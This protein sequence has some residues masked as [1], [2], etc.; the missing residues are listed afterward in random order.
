MHEWSIPLVVATS[1]FLAVLV[2]RVRPLVAPGTLRGGSRESLREAHARIESATSGTER[3]TAL[4]EA[5]ALVGAGGAKALLA[6]A[7]RAEP[8]SAEVVDRAAA[9][10]AHRPRA[11]ESL[12]W[13]RLAT[14]PWTESPAATRAALDHLRVLYEGPL[15]NAIRARAMAHAR[16]ALGL[17]TGAAPVSVP[18]DLT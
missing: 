10:L 11:L 17:R 6:R 14:T 16:D 3:A 2:W 4:C 1:A 7:M 12:L 9:M 8:T 13:R 5:A 18:S 15:R